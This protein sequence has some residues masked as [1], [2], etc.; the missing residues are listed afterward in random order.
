[1]EAKRI[2]AEKAVEYIE[3]GMI[4]GLGTGSTAYY[5]IKKVG[6]LISEG[7]NLKAVATSKSSEN[8]AN[9]FNIPLVS[10][11]KTDRI[12]LVIDGVDEIDD[13]FNAVKGGGGALFREKIVA[14]LAKNAIW[15]MDESKLV[16][17]IG[18]FPLP[19][20]ILPFGHT[21][22]LKQLSDFSLNPVLRIRD[23][24]VFETDNGNYIADLH[25]G[26]PLNIKEITEKL[27]SITGVLEVGLFL[28]MCGRIIV[29]SEREVKIIENPYFQ[30]K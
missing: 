29:G 1:M 4:L 6:E 17:A 28:N 27:N 11:D 23:G 3:D 22:I 2:A 30:K 13:S 25:I 26:K 7:M 14:R 15:I 5:M 24:K 12:D 19:V 20:E 16:D 8:L 9:E 10:I 18:R 21:H